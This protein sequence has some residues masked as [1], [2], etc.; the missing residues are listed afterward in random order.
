MSITPRFPGNCLGLLFPK[1]LLC[2]GALLLL[3]GCVSH[4]P[5]PYRRV[6]KDAPAFKQAVEQETNRQIAKGVAPKEAEEKAEKA[7]RRRTIE[8]EKERRKNLVTPLAQALD[9]FDKPRG[10]WAY[11]QRTDTFRDGKH[12]IA[13][14]RFDPSKPEENLWTLLS[15]D[16][17]P[18]GQ[19]ELDDY[20]KAKLRAWKKQQAKAG[21]KKRSSGESTKLRALYSELDV[22]SDPG[23]GAKIYTFERDAIHVTLLG[24]IP[25]SR[26][27]YHIDESTGQI[28]QR[29]YQLLGPASFLG[30]TAKILTLVQSD[31]FMVIEA[32]LPPF[33]SKTT[34]KYRGTS[35]GKDSGD[36]ERIIT[37]SDYR[38][39][40][41]YDDRFEVKI[42]EASVSEY[43]PER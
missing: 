25:K 31:T 6:D 30:G 22:S 15:K 34:A 12:S 28:L 37:Y 39:V 17:V 5:A 9:D 24:D 13:V 20:R 10:C 43:L 27:T 14:E 36:I 21:S 4:A 40:T 33:P 42:G 41:C 19:D 18:P 1:L 29:E 26:N 16:G 32:K 8:A 11:T 7:V 3:S 35:F 2:L 38:K 23:H